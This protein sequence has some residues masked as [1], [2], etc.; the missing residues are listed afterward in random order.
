L[1]PPFLFFDSGADGDV[2]LDDLDNEDVEADQFV[3]SDDVVPAVN[4]DVYVITLA[5]CL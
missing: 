4:D 3:E 5:K 2:E 1:S